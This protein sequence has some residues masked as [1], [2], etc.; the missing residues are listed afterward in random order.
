MTAPEVEPMVAIAV[1]ALLQVPPAVALLIEVINPTHTED[2]P[3]IDDGK[4]FTVT[5][6]EQKR[7]R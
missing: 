4:G 7:C 3:V 5:T 2:M 1:L 6:L